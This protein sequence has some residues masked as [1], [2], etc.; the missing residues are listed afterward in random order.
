M[1]WH[2]LARSRIRYPLV[3]NAVQRLLT[4]MVG[5]DREEANR[6]QQVKWEL[7]STRNAQHTSLMPACR[8]TQNTEPLSLCLLPGRLAFRKKSRRSQVQW[9][10][11]ERY[12]YYLQIVAKI[13]GARYCLRDEFP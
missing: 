1:G 7:L 6:L 4:A 12:Q 10:E 2:G 9:T 3:A 8:N 5:Q 13:C 11:G